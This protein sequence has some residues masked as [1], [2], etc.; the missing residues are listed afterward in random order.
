MPDE[1]ELRIEFT[2]EELRRLEA[3]AQHSGLDAAEWARR[4][5][6]RIL[7]AREK[8]EEDDPR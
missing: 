7:E 3:T 6:L 4:A 2:D 1:E 8:R 5:L